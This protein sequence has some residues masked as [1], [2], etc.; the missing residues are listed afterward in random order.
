MALPKGRPWGQVALFFSWGSP[1]EVP[2]ASVLE[3]CQALVRTVR[4]QR[5]QALEASRHGRQKHGAHLTHEAHCRPVDPEEAAASV[6]K[7][8]LDASFCV[9]GG[10]L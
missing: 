10:S 9:F 2:C 4:Q 6:Q 3:E 5:D 1:S 7:K 8:C